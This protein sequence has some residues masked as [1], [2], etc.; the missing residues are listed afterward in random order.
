MTTPI[1][2]DCDTGI[3]DALAIAF[4][5]RARAELAGIGTVSGNVSA[6]TAARNTLHLLELAG[7][8]E[9]PVAVGRHEPLA[10]PFGGGA[11]HVHGEEGLGPVAVPEPLTKPISGTAAEL[12]IQ[13]SQQHPARLHI[14]AIGPLT[15]LAAALTLDPTLPQR[16]AWVTVMG[17]A[18][19]VPGNVTPAAEANIWNDPEAASIVF[20]APWNITLVPLDVTMRHVIAPREVAELRDSADPLLSTVAEAF[21]TYLD[22]YSGVFESRSAA[23][24]DPLAAAIAID[25]LRI[26]RAVTGSITVD[27]TN[28]AERGRTSHMP[29]ND[30][31]G[32]L[33]E[34]SI[35]IE[36]ASALSVIMKA[37]RDPDNMDKQ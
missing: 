33:P 28:G 4:L 14:L 12:L 15:N 26:T 18:V 32:G 19:F 3:D 16:I 20:A 24:H 34:R 37:V 22:F 9:I 5:L 27:T 23:L 21:D 11:A 30:S 7:R 1:Y 31:E 17:G 13:L 10:G 6:A 8:P 36:T 35:V 25:A 29:L 2:L